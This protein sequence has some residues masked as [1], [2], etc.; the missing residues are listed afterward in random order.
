MLVYERDSQDENGVALD[1]GW[2]DPL[3]NI[4]CE[5]FRGRPGE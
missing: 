3:S 1:A 5:G 2:T 4:T